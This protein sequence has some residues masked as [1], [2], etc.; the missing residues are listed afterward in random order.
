MIGQELTWGKN[1]RIDQS[2]STG[3]IIRD[4]ELED[5]IARG[6]LAVER[7]IEKGLEAAQQEFNN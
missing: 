1:A 3:L 2:L 7:L 4:G 5:F 6:A